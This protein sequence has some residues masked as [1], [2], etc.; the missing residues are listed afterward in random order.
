[1]SSDWEPVIWPERLTDGSSLNR[2][3]TTWLV[4]KSQDQTHARMQ[5]RGRGKLNSVASHRHSQLSSELDARVAALQMTP[6]QQ[7]DSILTSDITDGPHESTGA[8]GNRHAA[9]S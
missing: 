1:M 9:C 7:A 5:D 3:K 4:G 2:G 6:T 8:D